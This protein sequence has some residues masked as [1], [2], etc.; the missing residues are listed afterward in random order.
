MLDPG[1]PRQ[2]LDLAA[3]L[4]IPLPDTALASLSP[5]DR[6]RIVQRWE[7]RCG[8]GRGGLGS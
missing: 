4:G 3:E 1:I 5:Q 2:I 6:D 7:Q 8:W